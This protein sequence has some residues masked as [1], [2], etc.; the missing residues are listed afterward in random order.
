MA[1]TTRLRS[2]FA[3]SDTLTEKESIA[4]RA[5]RRALLN[6][7]TV[8]AAKPARKKVAKKAVKRRHS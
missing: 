2:R 3:P 1:L 8:E 4:K 5:R 7:E 6:G